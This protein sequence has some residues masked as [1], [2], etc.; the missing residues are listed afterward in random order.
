MV[1]PNDINL[2]C[3]SFSKA[4]IP[5]DI[6]LI[7]CSIILLPVLIISNGKAIKLPKGDSRS[8]FPALPI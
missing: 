1:A 5:L 4:G 8:A 7:P 3:P 2:L 6:S